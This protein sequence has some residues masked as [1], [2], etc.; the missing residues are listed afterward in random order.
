MYRFLFAVLL[1]CGIPVSAENPMNFREY[2]QEFVAEFASPEEARRATAEISLLPDGQELAFTTRW[3]DVN[4]R[5]TN[6]SATMKK[7]SFGEKSS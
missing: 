6:M 5:H 2:T 1:L 3:D 4:K 7:H